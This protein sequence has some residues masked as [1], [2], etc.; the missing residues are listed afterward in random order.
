VNSGV[1]PWARRA[2]E[3][4]AAAT[5][6]SPFPRRLPPA[7]S[8]RRYAGSV[9]ATLAVAVAAVSLTLA[10]AGATV[11]EHRH[12]VGLASSTWTAVWLVAAAVFALLELHH[13]RLFFLPL[14]I[15]AGAAALLAAGRAPFAVQLVVFA[16]AAAFTAVS[17]RPVG[18]RLARGGAHSVE[19]PHRWVGR[20]GT[21]LE[22]IMPDGHGW[23][24]VGRE[25][26]RATSGLEARIAAG[27]TVLVTGVEGLHLIV[28][29]LDPDLP[30]LDAQAGL[31]P[32]RASPDEGAEQWPT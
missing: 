22:D 8:R 28:L 7:R 27:S 16:A 18:R 9:V 20:E 13:V 5:A 4:L 32:P 12:I 11:P 31:G 6:S 30:T 19:G 3:D 1:D 10:L 23:V 26:W 14:V 29:P 17:L 2:A 21:V 25:R 24:R 15:G